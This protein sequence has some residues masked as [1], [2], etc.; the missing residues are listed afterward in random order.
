MPQMLASIFRRSDVDHGLCG[1]LLAGCDS[2]V[3]V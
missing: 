2:V 3:R 1:S